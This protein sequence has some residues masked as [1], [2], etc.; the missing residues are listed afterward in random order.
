MF[1]AGV[2]I[3]LKGNASLRRFSGHK[4]QDRGY[5]PTG[6][7]DM[8]QLLVLCSSLVPIFIFLTLTTM[9][10]VHISGH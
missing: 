4:L 8:E 9:K 6:H 2:N 10:E 7:S 5:N 3:I 1:M